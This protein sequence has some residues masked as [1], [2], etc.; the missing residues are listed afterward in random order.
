[1]NKDLILQEL[2]FKAVRSGG[3]GGQ[4]VNKV[5]TKVELILTWLVPK[6]LMTLKKNAYIKNSINDLHRKTNSLFNVM[7][8][9]ANIRI[10]KLQKTVY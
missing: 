6:H 5:S 9:G 7:N 10:G 8:P 4:H 3:A 2:K 1:M